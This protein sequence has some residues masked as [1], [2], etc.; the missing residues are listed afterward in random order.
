MKLFL[1]LLLLPPCPVKADE[2]VTS[3]EE[4]YKQ[5]GDLQLTARIYE[6]KNSTVRK[7]PGIVSWPNLA[8][9]R[10]SRMWSISFGI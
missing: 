8:T 3:R 2:P 10:L 4:V 6:R 9:C 7:R 5:V 1:P